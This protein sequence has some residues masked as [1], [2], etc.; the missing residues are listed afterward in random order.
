M[1]M[2]GVILVSVLVGTIVPIAIPVLNNSSILKFT[3]Q[4]GAMTWH[5]QHI[6]HVVL[7]VHLH[8]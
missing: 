5:K 8:T 4:L 6:A 2:T 1:V 7:F 3:S